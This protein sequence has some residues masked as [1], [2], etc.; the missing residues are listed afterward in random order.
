MSFV[1][2]RFWNASRQEWFPAEMVAVT[3]APGKEQKLVFYD[4]RF[5]PQD[6]HVEAMMATG[7]KDISGALIFD[8]DIVEYD[9]Y[10]FNTKMVIRKRGIVTFE[11]G[12]FKVNH[13]FMY[14]T[15]AGRDNFKVIGNIHENP[16]IDLSIEVVSH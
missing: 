8:G 12:M 5:V 4:S 14:G 11:G 13:A 1:E 7:F 3:C 6:I 16:D 9:Q 2:L 15:N 10:H